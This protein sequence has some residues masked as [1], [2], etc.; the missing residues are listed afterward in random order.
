MH[1]QPPRSWLVLSFCILFAAGLVVHLLAPNLERK[2][3]AFVIPLVVSAGE[4][5]LS[6]VSIVAKE[7][8]MQS[9]SA[10]LTASGA[11]GLGFLYR[12]VLFQRA[13]APGVGRR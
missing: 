7:R 2:E 3:N 13:R 6:P 4:D 11:I 5:A 9:I 8:R 1:P 10:V 12:K